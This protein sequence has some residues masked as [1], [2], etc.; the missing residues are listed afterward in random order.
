MNVHISLVLDR[1][2]PVHEVQRPVGVGPVLEGL[3]MGVLQRLLDVP[4]GVVG[5]LLQ[6][7]LSLRFLQFV[8]VVLLYVLH[9]AVVFVLQESCELGFQFLSVDFLH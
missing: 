6:N 5:D 2:E 3:D 9:E 8:V 7:S 4:E 1:L